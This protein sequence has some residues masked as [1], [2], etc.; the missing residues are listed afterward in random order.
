M[1]NVDNAYYN[2]LEIIK[3]DN[4]QQNSNIKIGTIYNSSPLILKV[5]EFSYEEDEIKINADLNFNLND[6][7]LVVSLDGDNTQII[8]C[9]VR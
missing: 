6:S 9:R 5:G 4:K 3:G 8:I 2:L 1:N 7:V